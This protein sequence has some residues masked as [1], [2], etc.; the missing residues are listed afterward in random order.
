MLRKRLFVG[1]LTL[2]FLGVMFGGLFHMSTGMDMSVGTT[3]CPLMAHEETLCAMGL[4]EHFG[5]W[6]SHFLAITPAL[7]LLLGSLAAAAV[8]LSVAPHLR[9]IKK[10]LSRQRIV[11][12]TKR[13]NLCFPWRSLQELFS[14][15]ILHP[16]LF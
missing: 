7:G 16:K 6:K 10:R 12:H 2:L 13:E 11:L 1:L 5:E 3:G 8:L 4:F 15:G 14:S 9:F